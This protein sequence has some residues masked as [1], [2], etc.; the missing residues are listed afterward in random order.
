MFNEIFIQLII[1]ILTCC[2]TNLSPYIQDN[3][4]VTLKELKKSI[5]DKERAAKA[6]IANTVVETAQ[7]IIQSRVGCQVLVEV[8]EAY[9][10]TKALDSALK[11]IR[12][13]SPETSAL[14]ISIDR[15]VEKIFALSSVPKVKRLFILRSIDTKRTILQCQNYP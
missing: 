3:M 14:L 12:A 7:S 13:V 11:K 4:R 5:D 6:A 9:S 10:N 15:D 8:L 1:N 2:T